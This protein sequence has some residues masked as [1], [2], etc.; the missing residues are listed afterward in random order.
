MYLDVPMEHRVARLHDR[1][2]K[3]DTIERRI[4]TDEEQFSGFTDYEVKITNPDF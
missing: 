4:N 1:D 3:N 2:D